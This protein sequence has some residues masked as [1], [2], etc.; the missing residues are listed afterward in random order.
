[1]AWPTAIAMSLLGEPA[2]RLDSAWLMA[3][4][5]II[6]LIVAALLGLLFASSMDRLP[7]R[8]TLIVSTFYGFTIWIVASF[9]LGHWMSESIL[10]FNRTWWGC[11]AHLGFGFLLGVYA[12][13][14]GAGAK[15]MP[16]YSHSITT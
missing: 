9:I 3:V 13:R 5:L 2:T 10:R 8:E 7:K 16:S 11:L 12:V 1:M 6:H 4:G 14:F 15:S